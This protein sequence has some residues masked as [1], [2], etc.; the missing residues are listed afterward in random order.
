MLASFIKLVITEDLLLIALISKVQYH[1]DSK[2]VLELSY[3][4]SPRIFKALLFTHQ[5]NRQ[6]VASKCSLSSNF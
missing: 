2:N 5:T 1:N 4:S 3:E 6:N